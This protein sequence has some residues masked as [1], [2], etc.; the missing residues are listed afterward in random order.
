MKNNTK[1]MLICL[2]AI[3]GFASC[4]KGGDDE[5]KTKTTAEKIQGKWNLTLR[6]EIE[7]IGGIAEKDTE[8]GKPGEYLD[9]RTSNMVYLKESGSAEEGT[10]YTID[11]DKQ[12]TFIFGVNDKEVYAID[13]LTDNKLVLHS[14]VVIVPTK[15]SIPGTSDTGPKNT[16][17]TIIT[18]TR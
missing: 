16:R 14:K 6:E 13:V 17:E 11:S 4:K 7:T 5:E 18:L 9:F 15:S 8:A 1:L 3:L 10:N 2:I 12:L